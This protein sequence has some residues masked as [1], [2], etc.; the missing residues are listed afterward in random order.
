MALVNPRILSSV[1]IVLFLLLTI[2]MVYSLSVETRVALKGAV[3][4]KLM[5]VAS[6]TAS[7]IEADA[8]AQ[9]R[10]GDEDTPEF[11][12]VRDQLRSMK[13]ATTGIRYIYTMRKNGDVIAFVVDADFGSD[14]DAPHIDDPYPEAEPEMYAGFIAPSANREFT[15]DEWGTVLSGFSPIRDRAG[16]VVGI[17]GVDMDSSVVS[18]QLDYLNLFFYG[19]GIITLIAVVSGIIVIERR[20]VMDARRVEES[21][22]KYRL[23]FERAADAIFLL[24]AE[25]QGQGAILSAN[26]AAARMHGFSEEELLRMNLR[27]I[28]TSETEEQIGDRFNKIL[29]GT[30]LQGEATHLKRDRTVFS[31]EFSAGLLDLG[32]KRVIIAICRDITDRKKSD[33]ALRQVTEKLNLLNAVTFNDI[34]NALFTLNGYLSLS[35]SLAEDEKLTRTLDRAEESLKK[36]S[37][38]LNFAKSY[39]D[40]GAKPPRWQDVNQVFIL[41][42]SHLNFSGIG[43][44]VHLD[45]LEIFADSL[46]ERVFLSLADNVLRHAGTATRVT[47][48]Y[49]RSGENLILVFA[50]NG[51][52]I[53]YDRKEMIFERGFGSQKGLELFLIRE[54]LG[55][56]VI[57]ITETGEPGTGA[58][59]EMVIPK[60][61][62]Q[63]FAGCILIAPLS[64]L[65]LV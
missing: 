61:G 2:G 57:T 26:Q 47:L 18:A 52:G 20:R 54:I 33:D 25:G 10:A 31:V 30:W 53:S 12:R 45:N 9:I 59:F 50:D 3:Q 63:V 5:S 17:V 41:G 22:R 60:G 24:E 37:R 11:I 35:R 64:T 8:F 39:Q 27:D 55:I 13:E 29:K 6:I 46:L 51:Q 40:L 1:L 44:S 34:Q 28:E 43:R 62:V 7:Q 19:I 15:T 21:E 49:R 42:I 14:P 23:L 16:N 58:R 65:P 38:S 56:T 36:V 4:D 32:Q 48:D